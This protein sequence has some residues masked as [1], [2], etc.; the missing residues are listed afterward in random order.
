M[1][2]LYFRTLKMPYSLKYIICLCAINN[3]KNNPT[4]TQWHS[5]S[6]KVNPDFTE[7]KIK[8]QVKK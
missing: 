4:I 3:N 2:F 6:C 8:K 5:I 1:S 7:V